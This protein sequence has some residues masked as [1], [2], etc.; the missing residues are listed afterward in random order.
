MSGWIVGMDIIPSISKTVIL[1]VDLSPKR[2]HPQV[3][4][5]L[6]EILADLKS[7]TSAGV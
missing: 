6:L 7:M 4:R 1:L 2:I 5:L 3:L